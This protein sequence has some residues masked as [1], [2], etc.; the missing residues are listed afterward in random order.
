MDSDV[1]GEDFKK[2]KRWRL[3]GLAAV[4]IIGGVLEQLF[5][6]TH[7]DERAFAIGGM[8]LGLILLV[9]WCRLDAREQGYT[10]SKPLLLAIILFAAIGLLIYFIRTR[11]ARGILSFGIAVLFTVVLIALEQIAIEVTFFLM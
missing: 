11:G 1:T 10:I 4:S 3:I 5:S 9:S 8:V 6:E 2:P 7:A